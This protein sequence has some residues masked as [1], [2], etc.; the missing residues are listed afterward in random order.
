MSDLTSALLGRPYLDYC[1]TTPRI[2]GYRPTETASFISQQHVSVKHLA[3][4]DGLTKYTA[5]GL[6]CKTQRLRSDVT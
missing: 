5:S 2:N 6:F 4:H 1:I 3:L